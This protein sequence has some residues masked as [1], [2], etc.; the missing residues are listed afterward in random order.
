[1]LWVSPLLA[2][3]FK[4][5]IRY[6]LCMSIPHAPVLADDTLGKV[7]SFFSALFSSCV[8]GALQVT[9][10]VDPMGMRSTHKLMF[11]Y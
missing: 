2:S 3:P 6:H 11:M 10:E 7:P 8:K 9:Y 4:I 5:W 1:M